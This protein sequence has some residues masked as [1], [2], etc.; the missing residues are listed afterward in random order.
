MSEEGYIVGRRS[1]MLKILETHIHRADI[2]AEVFELA[3]EV[4][5]VVGS[6]C[7]LGGLDAGRGERQKGSGEGVGQ[8]DSS[9]GCGQASSSLLLAMLVALL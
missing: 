7:Q 1:V 3:E 5:E 4:E 2:D 9:R 8:F 6:K